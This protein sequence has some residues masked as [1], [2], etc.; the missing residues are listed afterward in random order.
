MSTWLFLGVI[1]L[2]LGI[3]GFLIVHIKQIKNIDK[4]HIRLIAPIEQNAEGIFITD[5]S[6]NIEYVNHGFE[7]ITGYCIDE[8]LGKN[9]RILK[10]EKEDSD[11]YEKMWETILSGKSWSGRLVNK[12]KDN[13]LTDVELS[14][15]PFF[16][17]SGKIT[18]FS[19]IMHDIT[20]QAKVERKEKLDQKMEA[21]GVYSGGLAHDFNNLLN[22]ILGYADLALTT[23]KEDSEA[24]DMLKEIET[25]GCRAAK[26]INQILIFDRK[27]EHE[28]EPKVIYPTIKEAIKTLR[29]KIPDNIQIEKDIQESSCKIKADPSEIHQIFMN[30]CI[31]A[32]QSMKEKGG[33][34]TIKLFEEVLF[35]NA[36]KTILKFLKITISDTGVG[37]KKENYEKIYDPYFTTRKKGDGKGLGLAFAYGLMH[38]CHGEINFQ[39]EVGKG[40]TFELLFPC[41]ETD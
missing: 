16:D 6:G 29:E 1:I 39:S 41:C 15:S 40:T 27:Q 35:D 3:I 7:K 32:I 10:S 24:Y 20:D 38:N 26:L 14:I 8:V 17:P 11:F 25:G 37:I 30:V 31:N 34:L 22:G 4:E 12:C 36:N 2:L 21:I 13:H 28:Y 19:A 5:I 9:P 18:Q 23:V 33:I